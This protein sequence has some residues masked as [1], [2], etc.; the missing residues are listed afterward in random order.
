MRYIVA[1]LAIVLVIGPPAW[2]ETP[3]PLPA[4]AGPGA[5]PTPPNPREP[6]AMAV[7]G[8]I[9]SLDPSNKTMTLEDGTT[10][11]I[12]ESVAT[13]ALHTGA[14]VIATYKEQGGHK[15]AISVIRVRPS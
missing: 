5:E 3:P 9:Q 1:T 14:R 10:L 13:T 15:V 8:K 6:Q 12:S 2:P 4:P 7:Q 11:T